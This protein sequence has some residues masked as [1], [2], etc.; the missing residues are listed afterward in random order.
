MK[1]YI[2]TI[3]LG[4][5]ILSCGGARL[6][7]EI[8]NYDY[9]DGLPTSV[10]ATTDI[11]SYDVNDRNIY[12]DN[13]NDNIEYIIDDTLNV[14]TIKVKVS[15]YDKIN[16]I[17]EIDSIIN[18]NR[19]ITYNKV[20]KVADFKYFYNLFIDN[21]KDKKIYNYT[22][23]NNIAIS[24]YMNSE[25]VNN[26]NDK[27]NLNENNFHIKDETIICAAMLEEIARDNNYIYYLNC[28]KSDTVAL[29]YDSGTKISVKTA[30]NTKIVTIY[31]LIAAGLDV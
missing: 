9:V 22:A 11:F 13:K 14:G 3:I 24:V 25:D 10:V 15:Y 20:E 28:L 23:F 17:K 2:I 31:E 29:I 19:V 18:G 5:I 21:L 26:V 16:S 8:M 7:L 6:T 27:D 12:F 30:L 4:F 1:K